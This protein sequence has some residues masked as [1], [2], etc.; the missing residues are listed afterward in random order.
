MADYRTDSRFDITKT[1]LIGCQR[2]TMLRNELQ[3]LPQLGKSRT[4]GHQLPS[5]EFTYGVANV[6]LDGGVPE[7]NFPNSNHFQNQRIRTY[8]LIFK[9]SSNMGQLC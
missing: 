6:K 8:H 4:R 5:N 3:F 2:D 9:S 1:G 7:G